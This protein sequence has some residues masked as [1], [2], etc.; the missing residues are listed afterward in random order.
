LYFSGIRLAGLG[1]VASRGK[2]LRHLTQRTAVTVDRI[3]VELP[4]KRRSA[5]IGM[6]PNKSEAA[7]KALW[8]VTAPG[9]DTENRR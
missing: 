2:L 3:P 7:A 9:Y 5:K 1:E 8:K 6:L 4:R